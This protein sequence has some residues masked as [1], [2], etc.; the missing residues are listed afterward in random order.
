[1]KVGA[2]PVE[3][4]NEKYSYGNALVL[5]IG[6]DRKRNFITKYPE[7]VPFV[8]KKLDLK[9]MITL[10]IDKNRNPD[11]IADARRI[12]F[13][14]FS[15]DIVILMSVLE[16]CYS[17]FENI[18]KEVNRVLSKN[19]LVIGFVPSFL[20]YHGNDY[21]RFTY[22]GI[23]RLLKDFENIKIIPVGGPFSVSVQIVVDMIKPKLLRNIITYVLSPFLTFMDRLL[24]RIYKNRGKINNFISRGYLF[25]INS[26]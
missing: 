10:E 3:N 19:G 26:R 14:D 17:N 6:A 22:E 12:P 25:I 11:I 13:K 4:L 9:Y 18:V 1:M 21:W 8:F 2:I 16:H 7:I 20:G 15:F 24:W 5:E 23:A